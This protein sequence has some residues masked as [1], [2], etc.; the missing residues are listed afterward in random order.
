[1]PV[2]RDGE[3]KIKIP[4]TREESW[5]WLDLSPGAS[6]NEIKKA[7]DKLISKHHPDKNPNS[8]K[9]SSDISAA[10][11]AA[12]QIL[13]GKGNNINLGFVC[14]KRG[15]DKTFDGGFMINRNY[16]KR[17]CSYEHAL[18][19]VKEISGLRSGPC[20]VCGSIHNEN[21]GVP[22]KC[23]RILTVFS[24]LE[25]LDC[26]DLFSADEKEH[27]Y[28]ETKSA[29]LLWNQFDMVDFEGKIKRILREAEKTNG[30]KKQ[31]VERERN[32]YIEKIKNLDGW[33]EIEEAIREYI[34]GEVGR[35]RNTSQFNDSLLTAEEEIRKVRGGSGSSDNLQKKINQAI[36]A[37]KSVLRDNDLEKDYE[38]T[39][40]ILGPDW[41]N[42][43]RNAANLRQV[44]ELKNEFIQKINNFVAQNE[45]NISNAVEEIEQILQ[46][47]GLSE[48]ILEPN[49]RDLFQGENETQILTELERLKRIIIARGGKVSEIISIS[50]TG[51]INRIKNKL[52]EGH[53]KLAIR[54]EELPPQL[55]VPYKTVEEKINSLEKL[56][57]IT[58][59][60]NELRVVIIQKKQEKLV[61]IANEAIAEIKK[62]IGQDQNWIE[63]GE[64]RDYETKLKKYNDPNVIELVKKNIINLIREQR[65]RP[66]KG[67]KNI[68]PN[69]PSFFDP[70]ILGIVFLIIVPIGLVGFIIL[71][72][73]QRKLSQ[74]KY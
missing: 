1:M 72:F 34:I 40:V 24:E 39:K 7:R 4:Q 25:L 74:R 30:E 26:W 28:M 44:E 65:G 31:E 37:I 73:W 32:E 29:S 62:E 59:F 17:C 33:E 38:K 61:D 55:L 47:V 45:N 48:N 3:G 21:T 14:L 71:R 51:S 13:T 52:K 70:K 64:H 41:E 35:C 42:Q 27:F 18:E 20:R 57:D 22:P 54:G 2:K 58:N 12:F 46:K 15:C 19:Y 5:E 53:E 23:D 63:L 50:K 49:W 56:E 67:F 9:E 11:N 66:D 60:E 8:K 43:I 10:I 6:G 69:K 16:N 68:D 36:V